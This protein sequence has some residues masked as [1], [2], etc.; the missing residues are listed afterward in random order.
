[1]NEFF[2]LADYIIKRM[3]KF[4]ITRKLHITDLHITSKGQYLLD[5]F[6]VLLLKPKA[7]LISHHL[8]F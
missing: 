6:F 1:M 4:V 5:T 8:I 3:R 7:T 2:S